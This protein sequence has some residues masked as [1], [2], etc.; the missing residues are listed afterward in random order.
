MTVTFSAD[1]GAG[2]GADVDVDADILREDVDRIP[3]GAANVENVCDLRMPARPISRKPFNIGRYG[4]RAVTVTI[5]SGLH[6]RGRRGRD[7]SAG[8]DHNADG[9]K[10]DHYFTGV[11]GRFTFCKFASLPVCLRFLNCPICAK[12]TKIVNVWFIL[13]RLAPKHETQ[14]NYNCAG[15]PGYHRSQVSKSFIPIVRK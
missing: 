13:L 15:I 1:A 7:M 6:A 2:A 4:L 10:K 14:L 12:K 9:P 11:R 5:I 3:R 8:R